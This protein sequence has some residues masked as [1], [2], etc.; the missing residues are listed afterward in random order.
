M[1]FFN[2]RKILITS[3]PTREYLDPVRYLSNASS[4]RMGQALAEEAIGAGFE[5]AVVSG[6]VGI[7]YP[8]GAEVVRVVTTEEMRDRALE[9]FPSCGG[10][11]GVAAPCDYRP[12]YRSVQKMSKDDFTRSPGTGGRFVLEL[13]ETPDIFAALGAVKQLGQWLVPFALETHNGRANALRKLA[14]KNGD[15]IVLNSQ[16]AIGSGATSV[17]VLNASGSTVASLSGNKR[18]AA[19]GIVRVLLDQFYRARNN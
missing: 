9:I 15:L 14:R 10:A 11:V 16:S 7:D 5:V 12:V 8:T 6:P 3:G 1:P 4:G 17:E 13:E 18:E 2:P 19:S